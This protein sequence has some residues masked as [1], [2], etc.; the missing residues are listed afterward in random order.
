MTRQQLATTPTL[1][2][3]FP[4]Q[5]VPTTRSRTKKALLENAGEQ[6]TPRPERRPRNTSISVFEPTPSS[7]LLL[8]PAT[9]GGTKRRAAVL[10]VDHNVQVTPKRVKRDANVSLSTPDATAQAKIS[11]ESLA[12]IFQRRSTRKRKN[13]AT[14]LDRAIEAPELVEMESTPSRKTPSSEPSAQETRAVPGSAASK[15]R[16]VAIKAVPP[17]PKTMLPT[18]AADDGSN[19]HNPHAVSK[20]TPSLPTTPLLS[21]V[22]PINLATIHRSLLDSPS[23]GRGA[24]YQRYRHL[25]TPGKKLDLPFNY[26]ILEKMFHGLEYTVMFMQGRGQRCIY[27]KIRKAVENMCNRNFELR[28]LAQIRTV[29]PEAYSYA[30]VLTVEQGVRIASVCIDMPLVT[31]PLGDAAGKSA[32]LS[33][34]PMSPS[35]IHGGTL[36]GPA[37]SAVDSVGMQK[38]ANVASKQSGDRKS[39][40]HRR[41]ETRVREAHNA[42]LAT[43]P[44]PPARHDEE[45]AQL[46][47]WHPNFDLSTVPD[48]EPAA[49]P[50]M[51]EAVIPDFRNSKAKI[52]GDEPSTPLPFSV[53]TPPVRPS[54]P[55]THLPATPTGPEDLGPPVMPRPP[56]K[57]KSRSAA[58]LER[59][60]EKER[61]KAAAVMYTPQLS[62]TAIRRNA[63]LSRLGDLAQAMSFLY[64]SKQR[65]V[66]DLPHVAQSMSNSLSCSLSVGEARDHVTLLAEV[67]PEWCTI[68]HLGSTGT[69]VKIDR[70]IPVAVIKEK[71]RTML[72]EPAAK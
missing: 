20:Y 11:D 52:T 66:L 8:S 5:K 45:E 60:R 72:T 15:R 16:F 47:A 35:V 9:P 10:D 63:M 29:Y 32:N 55:P 69:H 42:F 13:E 51:K 54:E 41:L 27:H 70:S 18:S 6:L 40:F 44:N 57:P 38:S 48:I 14:P 21:A 46:R 37:I 62:A 65:T 12:P 30:S 25:I 24:A 7:D 34:G 31:A 39:E 67:A 59:I 23:A 36:A 58:L 19:V 64:A 1:Q 28:H 43:M 4:P 53:G 68:T 17:V 22:K 56:S 33:D 71:V 50:E 49:M 61:K 3:F 2:T 26:Q